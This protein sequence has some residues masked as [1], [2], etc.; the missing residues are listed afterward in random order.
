MKKATE[1]ETLLW[2]KREETDKPQLKAMCLRLYVCLAI[3]KPAIESLYPIWQG[4]QPM[5]GLQ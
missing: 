2:T 3:T 1:I 4:E 5:T